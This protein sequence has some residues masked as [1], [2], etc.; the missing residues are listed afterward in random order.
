VVY[1]LDIANAGEAISVAYAFDSPE[2]D[3][4]VYIVTGCGNVQASCVAGQDSDFGT[5]S[6]ALTHTFAAPGTYYLI[7]DAFTPGGAG[8][9]LTGCLACPTTARATSW[10]RLKS[11]Y[12]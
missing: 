3:A 2:T 11:I 10:G 1:R 12:R 7:L 6:E 8:W 9:T 5:P 4:S